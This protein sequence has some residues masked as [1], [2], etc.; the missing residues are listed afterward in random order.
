VAPVELIPA[1]CP[2]CLT[3]FIIDPE[4]ETADITAGCGDPPADRPVVT[5]RPVCPGCRRRLVVRVPSE[6]SGG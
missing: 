1:R 6:P 4:V 5:Y 3:A 2:H